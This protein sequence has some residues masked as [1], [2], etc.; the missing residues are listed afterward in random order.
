MEIVRSWWRGSLIIT[1]E[2]CVGYGGGGVALA[3]RILLLCFTIPLPIPDGDHRGGAKGDS[4]I[5]NCRVLVLPWSLLDYLGTMVGVAMVGH[6]HEHDPRVVV[7][8][9]GC[10]AWLSVQLL[11]LG[12]V[13][14]WLAR[15]EGGHVLLGVEPWL[16]GPIRAR[17][18]VDRG[19]LGIQ[20][21]VV[22]VGNTLHAVIVKICSKVVDMYR[23]WV[24]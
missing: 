23:L 13:Q 1:S 22:G 8:V 19:V 14:V 2:L 3:L 16:G 9:V 21:G 20:G 15:R 4:T 18:G 7:W 24:S 11:W 17:V 6:G 5:C 10:L 12:V